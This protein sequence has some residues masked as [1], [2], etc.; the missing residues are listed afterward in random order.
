MILDRAGKTA[1]PSL[2]QA[3]D[4]L[5]L[6]AAARREGWQAEQRVREIRNSLAAATMLND[7]G[8]P[9]PRTIRVRLPRR[10]EKERT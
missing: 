6:E 9:M 2:F 4:W 5:A 1:R 7:D 8:P 10:F 3:L